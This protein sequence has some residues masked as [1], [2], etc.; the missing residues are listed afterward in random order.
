MLFHPVAFG[1]ATTILLH[2][3]VNPALTFPAA[4]HFATKRSAHTQAESGAYSRDIPPDS[5]GGIHCTRF[6]LSME[7][8][9]LTRDGTAEPVSRDQ[10]LRRE[11]GQGSIYFPCSTDHEQDWLPSLVDLK[12]VVLCDNHILHMICMYV[13]SHI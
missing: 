4:I 2:A 8:D 6:S 7:R 1:P 11:S 13:S 10:I 3:V 9:R 5:R 12:F